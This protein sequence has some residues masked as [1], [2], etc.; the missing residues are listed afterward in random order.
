MTDETTSELLAEIEGQTEDIPASEYTPP[1]GWR[2]LAVGEK[3]QPGDMIVRSD[4]YCYSTER[5]GY[6]VGLNQRHIR[7]IEP[8][9]EPEPEPEPQPEP[10]PD[11]ELQIRLLKEANDSQAETIGRLQ[12]AIDE[13]AELVGAEQTRVE[14]QAR[15]RELET[16]RNTQAAA[17]EE[18]RSE[19]SYVQRLLGESRQRNKEL[20]A[21]VSSLRT[22][23]EATEKTVRLAGQENTDL[24]HR[25]DVVSREWADQ[26]ATCNGLQQQVENQQQEYERQKSR[27]EF[28]ETLNAGNGAAIGDYVAKIAKLQG[29]VDTARQQ[30]EASATECDSVS[31]RLEAVA[32][33]R[34]EQAETI[35]R[36][37]IELDA[38]Q[39]VPP[40]VNDR[41]RE[42]VEAGTA[43][44]V[45]TIVEW[46]EPFRT[47]GSERLAWMVM[48]NLPHIMRTLTG[49]TQED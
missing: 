10:E 30:L 22:I 4:G 25:L 9:P 42:G 18:L 19:V 1:E 2:V 29:L 15:I 21:L 47:C 3:L 40:A 7:R 35:R 28:L 26:A 31:T 16:I 49:L 32:A 48:Q 5:V 24:K 8:Q 12:A 27:I 11:A 37:Q 20:E 33:E 39:Q 41:F 34:D 36:L 6:Y 46:T 17:I 44:A 45:E 23:N 38:A 13:R 43:R 14:L